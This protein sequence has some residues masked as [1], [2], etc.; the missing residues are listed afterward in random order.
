MVSVLFGSVPVSRAVPCVSALADGPS[1]GFRRGCRAC[2]CLLGLS[3]F[4][5][6][7]ASFYGGCPAN[8]LFTQCQA[9]EGLSVRQVVTITWDPHPREPVEGVLRAMSTLELTA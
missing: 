5:A 9:L 7:Y 4:Q 2:L 1:G 6:S 3:W 8:S